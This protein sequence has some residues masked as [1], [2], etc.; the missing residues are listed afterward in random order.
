M[1]EEYVRNTSNL[2]TLT[3]PQVAIMINVKDNGTAKKWLKNKGIK[4]HNFTKTTFVYQIEVAS[5]ID[6][7]FVLQLRNQYPDKWKERYRDVVKDFA[8]YNLLLS[9]IEDIP[10]QT[11]TV[12]SRMVNKKDEERYNQ[13]LGWEN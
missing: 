3:I 4:I 12:K 9:K 5:E 13:L 8:V 10:T 7:P 11:P 2:D 1:L 6:K